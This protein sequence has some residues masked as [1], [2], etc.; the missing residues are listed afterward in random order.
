VSLEVG[1]PA[2]DFE[3]PDQ[4]GQRVPLASFRGS[5]PVLLV[6]YPFVFSRVCTGELRTLRDT[7]ADPVSDGVQLL[8]I[9]CDPMFSLRAFADADGLQFPLLSDFWPHGAVSSAYGIFDSDRGC[10]TRSSFLIDR[11]GVVRWLA[12]NASRDARD[13]ADYPRVLGDL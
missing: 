11:T 6:F 7:W 13:I 1:Q 3:L 5:T 8:A 10:P 12:H 4:H 2:P 9:S